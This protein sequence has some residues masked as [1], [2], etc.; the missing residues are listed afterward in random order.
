MVT[1][2]LV[3]IRMSITLTDKSNTIA[4]TKQGR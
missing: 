4:S 1:W 2:P 3:V